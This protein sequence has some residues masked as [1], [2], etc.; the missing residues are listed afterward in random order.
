MRDTK[1]NDGI[2]SNTLI[3]TPRPSL[4]DDHEYQYGRNNKKEALDVI[5][6]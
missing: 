5:P 4:D 2:T 3:S 1:I 6:E